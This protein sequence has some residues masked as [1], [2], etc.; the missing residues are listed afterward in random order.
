M[1]SEGPR[2]ELLGVGF[3]P[4]SVFRFPLSPPGLRDSGTPGLWDP[5]DIRVFLSPTPAPTL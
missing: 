4:L 2:A 3:F 1:V 5:K